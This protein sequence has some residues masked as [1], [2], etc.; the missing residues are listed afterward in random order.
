MI[1]FDDLSRPF[2]A[3]HSSDS[4]MLLPFSWVAEAT[5]WTRKDSG[6]RAVCNM[7]SSGSA[8]VNF[9]YLSLFHGGPGINGSGSHI[10][11][12]SSSVQ[13]TGQIQS[14]LADTLF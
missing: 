14:S 7:E 10:L 3:L 1:R 13:G 12:L 5:S 6:R 2:P 11:W 4:V 9:F 8:C